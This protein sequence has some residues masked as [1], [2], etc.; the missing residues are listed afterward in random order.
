MASYGATSTDSRKR[1]SSRENAGKRIILPLKKPSYVQR[2]RPNTLRSRHVGILRKLLH[3]LV[4]QQNWV[5]A[6]GVLS[7][8]L[9]ATNK[10]A[11]PFENQF[12]YSVLLRL[13]KHVE[14]GNIKPRRI[15]HI[16]DIWMK[17][18]GKMKH[19][20]T[21]NKYAVY[22]DYMLFFMMQGNIQDAY[23]AVMW[24]RQENGPGGDHIAN[25]VMGLI[26][27]EL[28]YS[29]I[30]KEFQ[31]RNSD[32]F[33]CPGTSYTKGDKFSS[34]HDRLGWHKTSETSNS[35]KDKKIDADHQR[36]IPQSN[37][38][39]QGFYSDSEEFS[40]DMDV[41]SRF[42]A[43]DAYSLHSLEGLDSW[44]L[45]LHLPDCNSVENFTLM[46]GKLL[47][48]NYRNAVRYLQ[49]ALDST[50]SA[51]ASLL[52]L[53]Q[54][55]LIGGRVDEALKI[56]EKQCCASLSAL[57]FR[58]KAILLEQFNSNDPLLLVS[59]F[60]DILEKD[61]TCS[62]TLEKLVKMHDDGHYSVESLVEIIASHLDAANVEHYDTWRLFASCFLRLSDNKQG[63][64]Q[65]LAYKAACASHMYGKEFHYVVGAY[66]HLEKNDQ[67]L[68]RILKH[69][70]RNSYRLY[71]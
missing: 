12:K 69:H 52:P 43:R 71:E 4:N 39:P 1:K 35:C 34:Q 60:E 42:Y 21:E 62:E 15:K 28:W 19:K 25:M 2:L 41:D 66:S 11:S 22:V 64:L 38:Q 59:C 70:R 45:P 24:I 47:N 67:D 32:Q 65:L 53:I 40:E 68:L 7:V 51:S 61:P 31:W 5:E 3:K 13:L 56:I 14:N 58:L 6:S 9:R 8:Y 49:I 18:N 23:E 46:H 55:L 50:P 33:D 36:K 17:R 26:Y 20:P 37:F 16:Y 57:P 44:L 30:P 63:D 10:D 27:Y 54:L 29:C 48:E